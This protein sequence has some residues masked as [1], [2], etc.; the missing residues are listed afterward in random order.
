MTTDKD[1]APAP[2]LRGIKAGNTAICTVG[3]EG[4]GL[5]YRGYSIEDLAPNSSFEEVS[6]LLLNGA[7]PSRGALEAWSGRLRDNRHLPDMVKGILSSLP[8]DAN[9]MD[10]L[11]TGVSALGIAEPEQGLDDG[12]NVA[13]RLLGALPSMLGCWFLGTRGA[14]VPYDIETDRFAEY[15]LRMVKTDAPSELECRMMDCSLIL[16]AEHEFNASTF[17][18]RTCASTL[19][20]FHSCITAA[21][22]TLRG[23]LH[24]GANEATMELVSRFSTPEAAARAIL[25][26]LGKRQ[27]VM[28][29]GHAVYK[30][31]DPRNGM[32][33]AWAR[34]LSEARN[35]TKLYE[36][37][38]A[39][40]HVMHEEKG[41]FPN[42]DF[43]S[44][45]AY[46]MAGIETEL[47]TPLFVLSRTS[48]W[49]AHV[50][51][52]R[53]DNKLIRPLASYLGPEPRE[54]VP[55]DAR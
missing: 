38:Q 36:I 55:I 15:V 10:V 4:H 43:Y 54:Y 9:G 14:D 39:I 28:G 32:I 47:F 6:Y 34:K 5:H 42:R 17:T 24:G 3:R 23:P 29:F 27:I 20:D 11:R 26:M 51:E 49:S 18:A 8:T 13:V 44:A 53:R 2:G 21:I 35:D 33:K 7:L 19:S 30:V 22:G 41:L 50:L 40:D 46:H 12:E 1:G 48:G 25:D 16:Y 37:S 31:R 52:Q 45:T